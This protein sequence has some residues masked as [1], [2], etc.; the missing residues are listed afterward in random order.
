DGL[1]LCKSVKAAENTNHI[2][3]ILLTARSSVWHQVEG[4]ASG[5]DAYISKPFNTRIL[6]LTIKNL[7]TAKE[8]MREKF[9]QQMVLESTGTPLTSNSPEGKFIVKLMS[10]I[11]SKME[12]PEFDVD[13]LVTE[14]G[15]SRSVLYKKVQALTNYS[16]ADLIKEMRLKKA[17][18]LFKQTTMSVADVAFSVGFND[19][20]YFSKEFRKHY[21]VSPSK[22]MEANQ[23]KD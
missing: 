6:E 22:F 16:V 3:V 2:P 4:L 23:S 17:A 11:E 13:F 15:M 12:D 5:A 10:I 19:R 14:I 20:K 8:I 7:L 21:E 1:T 18:K 9:S